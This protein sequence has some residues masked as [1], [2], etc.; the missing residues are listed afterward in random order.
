M[1]N[2]QRALLILDE[3]KNLNS[4]FTEKYTVVIV[5]SFVIPDKESYSLQIYSR[6]LVAYVQFW[7]PLPHELLQSVT[8]VNS[9]ALFLQCP[10]V[11]GKH[12][13]GLFAEAWLVLV[14]FCHLD[15]CLGS[16]KFTFLTEPKIFRVF[17]CAHTCVH[18][19]ERTQVCLYVCVWD[20]TAVNS[21]CK[22]LPLNSNSVMLSLFPHF[23]YHFTDCKV[24]VSGKKTKSHFKVFCI[25]IGNTIQTSGILF[26]WSPKHGRGS[27]LIPIFGR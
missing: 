5:H 14:L 22:L 26:L 12:S 11:S 4:F 20:L 8:L 13:T 6:F 10:C 2:N 9:R 21:R 16:Q 1:V 15:F 27:Y 25:V 3:Q 19:C 24:N 23:I 18:S 7:L 17:V